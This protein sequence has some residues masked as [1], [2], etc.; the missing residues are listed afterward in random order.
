MADLSSLLAVLEHDPDDAQALE[1]LG[2]AARQASPDVRAS[3]FTAARKLLAGR[4]RPDTVV[5]L[6][7]IEVAST[8]DV[9]RKVD[10]LLEKGM[11]LD[12]DLLDVAGARS[13][14][15][16]V[17]A[18]RSDDTM[19]KEAIG[20]LDLA[21]A[22]WQKF[23][24]KYVTEATGSTDRSLATGLYVSAAEAYV[25]FS[26]QSP[27]AEGYLRKALEIDPKNGKAA[28]HLIRLLRRTERWNDLSGLLEQRGEAAATTEEK[29]SALLY[30][31][32]LSLARND[33]AGAE[34][35]V[36][37][38]LQLDPAQP[39]ALRAV[40]D[41]FAAA[42]N[43][44][45]FVTA[46]QAALKAKRSDD[47]LGMLLQIA[48]VLW[49]HIGDLDQAEEYFR[50]VRKI[51]PAHPAALDFYRVYY[52]AKGENQKLLAL[53]RQVEKSPR[54]R[55]G[56]ADQ[57]GSMKPLGVEIAV[58]A[59]Q[60]NN[61]EKAIEAWKQ[62]VRNETDPEVLAQARTSLARLYRR[63]EKWNALLD[64]MK[65]EI[66]RTP[67]TNV[68]GRVSKLHEVVEIY[69]DKLRLDVM[70]I[71]TY[72]AI[73]KID[74]DNRRATD[75]L[76]NKFR[77]LGRWNDLIAVLSRKSEM[78]DIPDAERVV[79]LREIADLWSERFGNFAN[80]IKPLEKI[81]ELSP[82]SADFGSALAQLK[83]IY[84]KRRQWRAL[85][86]VLGREA[87]VLGGDDRRTKQ[88]EM[89]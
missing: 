18:L 48:M 31:A 81:L 87:S 59:E 24:E 45:S 82:G 78:P 58:L 64:L 56:S 60:Q 2:A 16:E 13:A 17:I 43:W 75:E 63:T 77:L 35:A 62:L 23:A 6:L 44:S 4:G 47:D 50:R 20:E 22:N 3:R 76:A 88:A 66:E 52:P 11:I 28:F 65:E 34:A 46:F 71:N 21:A 54:A 33:E 42:G 72:N 68:A 40:T 27:E 80:A 10:L 51:E 30:L 69:R 73:L 19:A 53:L 61:P 41:A 86:D 5:R 26:P 55:S 89:A 79:L 67:E 84:T 7:E 85:I 70:V 83:E 32:Q 12:G 37:R 49:K 9:E 39:Q 57:A 14:F 25:R 8:G 15:D 29:V 1:A 38:V 74:P 36:R